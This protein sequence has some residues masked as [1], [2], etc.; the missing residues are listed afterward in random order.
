[1]P[2]YRRQKVD[3]NSVIPE[4]VNN[5]SEVFTFTNIGKAQIANSFVLTAAK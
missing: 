3:S 5:T 1:M 2:R 4:G